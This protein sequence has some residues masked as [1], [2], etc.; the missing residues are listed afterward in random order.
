[1]K[2]AHT[3]FKVLVFWF[4][5]DRIFPS[6]TQT[7]DARLFAVL[8]LDA[9]EMRERS[10]VSAC[11]KPNQTECRLPSWSRSFRWTIRA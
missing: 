11:W 7:R 4:V 10:I 3:V 6:N 5:Q 1:M 2:R 8:R 9:A